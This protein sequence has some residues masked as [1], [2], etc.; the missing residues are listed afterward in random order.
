[1]KPLPFF[2]LS[3]FVGI[4][5]FSS[6][7]GDRTKI[8]VLSIPESQEQDNRVEATLRVADKTYLV[9][10]PQDS[11]VHDLMVKAQETSD[12][13]FK[14][15][16]FPGLGFFVQELNGVAENPRQGTFWIYYING[17]KAKV[18]ISAYTVKADDI[19]SWKYEDEE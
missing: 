4:V 16:E 12:F 2:L 3:A 7:L 11:S 9:S 1:M 8:N 5:T 15:R 14:G 6:I 18:G 19:I 10:L 17:E 13:Q